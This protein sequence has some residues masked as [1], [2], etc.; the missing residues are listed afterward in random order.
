M[1]P[2]KH[3]ITITRHRHKVI[4]YCF[5]LGIGF[6]GLFHDLSK[7]GF[8]EFWEGAKYYQGNRSPNA[9]SREVLGFSKAW[10]HHKGRNKHHYEYWS[11]INP[12]T[13]VYEPVEMPLRYLKESFADR[14]AASRIYAGKSYK[15]SDPL[16][17]FNRADK[18]A[19]MAPKTRETLKEW[20]TM[21]QEKGEKVTL[22]YVKSLKET[23]KLTL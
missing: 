9:K 16:D 5:K 12:L 3:F 6:Q 10:L 1:H 18:H 20:L 21:L 11:D 23:K 2:F 15:D 4:H 8:T 14:I 13:H 17:Y 7:Y 22:K 19:S